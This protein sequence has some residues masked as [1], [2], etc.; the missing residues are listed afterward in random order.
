MSVVRVARGFTGRAAIVKFEEG[1]T[2]TPTA[3]W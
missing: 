3:Y 2:V 1:T